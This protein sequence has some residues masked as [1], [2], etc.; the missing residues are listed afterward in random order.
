[1]TEDNRWT[2]GWDL[3]PC[4][5]QQSVKGPPCICSGR[6]RRRTGPPCICPG[7]DRRRT[8]PTCSCSG[9]DRRRTG[10]TCSCS[11]R[12]R[13]R[14]GVCRTPS[15][16]GRSPR[17]G[18]RTPSNSIRSPRGV[19][20]V[21]GRFRAGR[22]GV[23]IRP[24]PTATPFEP[25]SNGASPTSTRFEP[26][27]TWTRPDPSRCQLDMIR[28]GSARTRSPRG[29]ESQAVRGDPVRAAPR[30][31]SLD[32]D[33]FATGRH[34]TSSDRAPRGD[35][36]GSQPV[37]VR[38]LANRVGLAQMQVRGLANRFRV[39]RVRPGGSR[40]GMDRSGS[41]AS[42]FRSIQIKDLA[43]R[44]A[45]SSSPARHAAGERLATGRCRSSTPG[46][47]RYTVPPSCSGSGQATAAWGRVHRLLGT[48]G[49]GLGD[50]SVDSAA[51]GPA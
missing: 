4:R 49:L 31:D 45:P 38:G 48:F 43:R 1:M 51:A 47:Q 50:R 17:G 7:L 16:S 15:T 30:P 44:A 10:P 22:Q 9:R 12:D 24:C 36:I 8:G 41:T 14:T 26:P 33:P 34:P 5:S 32:L 13:R 42:R 25:A 27:L 29:G 6:D 39:F 40:T 3:Y 21:R 28:T 11:G 35:R 46:Y 20:F 19:S 23:G 18:G 2:K 37:R